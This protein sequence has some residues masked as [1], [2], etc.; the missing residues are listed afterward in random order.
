MAIWRAPA[1]SHFVQITSNLTLVTL[2]D[3]IPDSKCHITS[4]WTLTVMYYVTLASDHVTF[5][6]ATPSGITETNVG[7]TTKV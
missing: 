7:L 1:N 5:V 4:Y 3:V 6:I 2:Y